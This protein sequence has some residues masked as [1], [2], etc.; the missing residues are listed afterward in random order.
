MMN[1]YTGWR[2]RWYDRMWSGYTA[3]TIA[4]TLRMVDIPLLLRVPEQISRPPRA[5]DV[6][7]GTG[8]LLQRLLERVPGLQAYGVDASQQMLAQAR[9]RLSEWLESHLIQ[10]RV[11]PGEL[12]D[13]AFPPETFDLITCTNALHYFPQPGSSV[14]GFKRWLAAEGQLVLEDFARREAPFP[15]RAF[16]QLLRQVDPDHVQ[17]YSLAEAQ[18]FCVQAALQVHEAEAF[19]INWLWQGWALRAQAGPEMP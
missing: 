7:C 12:A 8:V 11:G 3:S 16:E 2:A 10:A 6:A 18:A 5:L 13:L 15:W 17:A 9:Q 14:A 1:T 4:A 19:P